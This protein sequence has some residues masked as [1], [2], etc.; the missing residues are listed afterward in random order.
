[1]VAS[2]PTS[3]PAAP[4]SPSSAGPLAA[5]LAS[6]A[7]DAVAGGDSSGGGG[8]ARR[9]A[10]VAGV[11]AAQAALDAAEAAAAQAPQSER[12]QGAAQAPLLD[13]LTAGARAAEAALG[14]ALAALDA[15]DAF[16]RRQCAEATVARAVAA[17]S[18]ERAACEA[19]F[20]AAAAATIAAGAPVPFRGPAADSPLGEALLNVLPIAFHHGHALELHR[21]RGLC[22]LTLRERA[23]PGG[24]VATQYGG[25]ELVERRAADGVRVVR[26]PWAT[27]YTRERVD[28]RGFRG[29]PADVMA[30]AL[31]AQAP[32]LQAARAAPREDTKMRGATIARTTSLIRAAAAGDER[33]VRELLAAGAPLH[34]VDGSNHSSALHFAS[35]HGSDRIVAALLAADAAGTTVHSQDNTG[36]TALNQ[37]SEG[38]RKGAVRVLLELRNKLGATALHYASQQGNAHAVAALLEADAA[39]TTLDAQNCFGNTALVWASD[40]GHEGAV[41]LLLARGARQELRNENG[42]TALHLAATK[43]HA[44]IVEQL[45]AAPGAAA[46]VAL[47][48]RSGRTPLD[49]AVL[50]GGGSER[51]VAALLAADQLEATTQLR[52]L[53]SLQKP[54]PI[55]E[56]CKRRRDR[57]IARARLAQH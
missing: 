41:R 20:A 48:T 11:E 35:E 8:G 1:M 36:D 28:E 25:G 24:A 26:L 57:E 50:E 55:D 15:H 45:C 6:P 9:A 17:S 3:S 7:A 13:A 52:R 38:G 14:E 32:L 4:A 10:L 31:E 12:S 40:N 27:L 46:V 51:I 33:R 30:R 39:G 2:Q 23:A 43:G 22:G 44:G 37:A 49:L 54:P 5:A 19:R 18:A 34:C 16:E 42:D 56:V 21:M 47:R 53:L 29:G